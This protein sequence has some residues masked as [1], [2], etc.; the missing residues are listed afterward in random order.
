MAVIVV[1]VSA[2]G[3]PGS[4]QAYAAA[5]RR[6]QLVA[7]GIGVQGLPINSI[8]VVRPPEM[9]ARKSGSARPAVRAE[10]ELAT[11]DSTE[12]VREG[13]AHLRRRC[14]VLTRLAETY[15][16]PPLRRRPAGFPGLARIVI[17]Q[18]LSVASADAIAGRL[19]GLVVPLTAARLSEQSDESLRGVGLSFPKIRTLRAL[20]HALNG[21]EIDLDGL[22]QARLDDVRLRLS[23][24]QGIGCW[25][26]DIYAMFC[27]GRRDAFAPGDLALQEGVR[28]AYG[29]EKRPSERQLAEKAEAWRPWRAVAAA[30]IWHAYGPLKAAQAE[31]TSA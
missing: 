21:N 15:G 29:E 17:G 27:L 31:R 26:A 22:A 9:S 23:R 30:L 24:V 7:T 28:L 2:P 12:D 5:G 18:Q 25:T 16:D 6:L 11:L 10:Q 19:E 4:P 8:L 20:A 13:M 14:R 3:T 1:V